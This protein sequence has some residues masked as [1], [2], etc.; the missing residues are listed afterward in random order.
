M[1]NK[2]IDDEDRKKA[3][4]KLVKETIAGAGKPAPDDLPHRLRDRAERHGAGRAKPEDYAP[5]PRKR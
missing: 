4:K 5:K 3:I 2:S 1:A